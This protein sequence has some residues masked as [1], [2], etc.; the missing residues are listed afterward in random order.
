M[1]RHWVPFFNLQTSNRRA[2]TPGHAL[3]AW[4]SR[5]LASNPL[6]ACQAA[7]DKCIRSL[8]WLRLRVV[9]QRTLF[10]LSDSERAIGRA[11]GLCLNFS[12]P[13]STSL[14]RLPACGYTTTQL[15]PLHLMVSPWLGVLPC[16]FVRVFLLVVFVWSLFLVLSR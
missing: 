12:S 15:S 4:A 16:C 5:K 8:S 1:F 10:Q 7:G 3:Q 14:A 13:P 9:F 2:F 6:S 11:V